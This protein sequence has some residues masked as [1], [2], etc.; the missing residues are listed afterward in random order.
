MFKNAAAVQCKQERVSASSSSRGDGAT[1]SDKDGE[2]RLK[3]TLKS[4][5]VDT[6]MESFPKGR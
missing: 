1:V 2:M 5:V 6:T 3:I 4:A